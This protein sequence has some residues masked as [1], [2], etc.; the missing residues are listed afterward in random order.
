MGNYGRSVRFGVMVNADARGYE[1]T[2]ALM[3]RADEAGWTSSAASPDP[4]H[5]QART[6]P[7]GSSVSRTRSSA[8][9]RAS[10]SSSRMP[11]EVSGDVGD[12]IALALQARNNFPLHALVGEYPQVLAVSSLAEDPENLAGEGE[13]HPRLRPGIPRGTMPLEPSLLGAR[14]LSYGL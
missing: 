2:S 4:R 13:G 8:L 11:A 5:A 9:A 12:V 6:E 1:E 10:T 14:C 3:R 7:K